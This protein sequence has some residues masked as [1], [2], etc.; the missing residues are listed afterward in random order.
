M[1]AIEL[2]VFHCM[3]CPQGARS[4][5]ADVPEAPAILKYL[6]PEIS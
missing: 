5:L 6:T 3:W 4:P 1:L 2:S